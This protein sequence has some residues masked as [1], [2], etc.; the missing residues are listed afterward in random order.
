MYKVFSIILIII[1][2]T[3]PVNSPKAHIDDSHH[4]MFAK[5]MDSIRNQRLL[6]LR[7][8]AIINAVKIVES[9]NNPLAFNV[10]E[11]A[12]GILQIRPIMVREV[13]RLVG[14]Q[15]Y[16]LE[17]RWDP[18][19][20]VGMFIDYQNAVNPDWCPELAAKKWNGGYYGERIPMTEIYWQKVKLNMKEVKLQYYL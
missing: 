6:E 10:S 1:S 12:A 4:E 2:I 19:K 11:Q 15:K 20:S 5:V 9:N 7:I 17:D 8:S 3:V 13:N 16:T 18:T 14:Y